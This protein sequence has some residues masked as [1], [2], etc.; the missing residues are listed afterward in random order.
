M[1]GERRNPALPSSPFLLPHPPVYLTRARSTLFC[2]A[3]L[4]SACGA[5]A[6]RYDAPPNA[7]GNCIRE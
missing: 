3:G 6:A 2:L 5:S 4:S 7:D 1:K